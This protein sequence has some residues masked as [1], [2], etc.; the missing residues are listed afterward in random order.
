MFEYHLTNHNTRK[1]G[2]TGRKCNLGFAGGWRGRGEAGAVCSV[3][4]AGADGGHVSDMSAMIAA[5]EE[6]FGG[7]A[8]F[9]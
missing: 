1:G 7:E 8:G 3:L 9:R 4:A 2:D 6:G 5:Q